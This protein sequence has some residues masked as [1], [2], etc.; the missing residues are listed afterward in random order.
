M[1][2]LIEGSP[3]I[4]FL[5]NQLLISK[6]VHEISGMRRRKSLKMIEVEFIF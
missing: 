5:E 1:H 3:S 2:V 4:T 6:Q